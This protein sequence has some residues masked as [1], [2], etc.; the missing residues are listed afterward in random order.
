MRVSLRRT[1]T[2]V[3]AV[4]VAVAAL[5]LLAASCGDDPEDT[6]SNNDPPASAAD[7]RG[8]DTSEDP[9]TDPL[10][11]ST[12]IST[13]VT[14]HDLVDGTEVRLSFE[15]GQLGVSAGCNSMGGAYSIVDDRLEIEGAMRTTE[16]ACEAPLMDQDR[17][18]AEWV[19]KGLT[20]QRDGDT[21]TLTGGDVVMELVDESAGGT[22]E[23]AWQLE[24]IIS[25]E[26]AS[27]VPAEVET[28]TMEITG[29]QVS[30]FTGCNRGGATV[31]SSDG[32]LTF[33]P[34]R[35]TRMA[36]AEAAMQLEA[37]VA[38]AFEGTVPFTVTAD[39]LTIGERPARLAACRGL[40]GGIT[41]SATTPRSSRPW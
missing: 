13:S 37:T 41:A 11:G 18:L 19:A 9:V 28:P 25:S 5:N 16:M 4:G 1:L 24:T 39:R 17:W 2:R 21:L 36:C 30:V 40:T 35:L 23:G 22:I 10:D 7:D 29:D 12:F 14:G 34:M 27:S 26:A 20:W 8:G 32:S 31:E 3:A 15:D 6:T 38:A 33:G